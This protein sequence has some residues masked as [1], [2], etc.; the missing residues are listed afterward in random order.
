[1]VISGRHI[2]IDCYNIENVDL[3]KKCETLHELMN[4]II[5]KL[6]LN[7]VN[8]FTYDF[9]PQGASMVYLLQES[10][11][12]IHTYPE[13]NSLS[14]DLYTC[15]LNTDLNEVCHIVYEFFNGK[16]NILKS[17]MDRR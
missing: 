11:L 14:L 17:I 3:I 8:Y 12:T 5:K 13:K 10:H 15:N 6:K 2:L 7:V 16:C 4:D 1:M 9:K